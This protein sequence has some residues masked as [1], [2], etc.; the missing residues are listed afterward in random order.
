M[1][2]R[3]QSQRRIAAEATLLKFEEELETLRALL[4]Q[5]IKV[6]LE[7]ARAEREGIEKKL[8]GESGSKNLK[9]SGAVKKTDSEHVR[10]PYQGEYWRDE[11]GTYVV[12]FSMCEP[13]NED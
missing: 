11:L 2:A 3:I 1:A 4:S 7:V 5:S 10:W 9:A 13:L 6:K 8:R 12:D